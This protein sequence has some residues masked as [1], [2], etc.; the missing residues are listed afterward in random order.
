M[1]GSGRTDAGAHAR[2]QVVAFATGSALSAEVLLRAINT[3][4]PQ[5]VNIIEAEEVD[6]DFHPRFD[7]QSRTYQYVI[8]N[9]AI[10]SP[11]WLGRSA[12]VR[13]RLNVDLMSR[14]A[15][16]LVGA[17]DFGA[18]VASS[19]RGSR[20]RLMYRAECGRQGD[21]VILELEASGFMRQMVRSIAGTL[22]EVGLGKTSTS[23]FGEILES[24]DRARAATTAPACGLYLMHVRYP[25]RTHERKDPLTATQL[26]SA[27]L[28]EETR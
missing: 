15:A 13:A 14:A 26:T 16:L 18:F 24:G 2:G 11:F 27:A 7:A 3:Y 4:L 5:D 1:F 23:Q 20:Q 17:R 22:I 21:L 8:W 25:E 28:F 12:H 19:A 6:L 9:R 10:R